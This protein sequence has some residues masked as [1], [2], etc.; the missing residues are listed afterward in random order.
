MDKEQDTEEAAALFIVG[1]R[2]VVTWPVSILIPADGGTFREH[3]V[4]MDLLY[5]QATALDEDMSVLGAGDMIGKIGTPDD[6]LWEK[7]LGWHGI[8]QGSEPMPFNEDN[9]ALVLGDSLIRKGIV[10]AL[11]EMAAG[12][13]AK[14]SETLPARG[15]APNRKGRRA[16]EK[17][18]K[19]KHRS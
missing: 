17:A 2:P 10:K 5:T 18:R 8:G 1:E 7:V 13:P 9:K 15:S 14:N 19:K 4:S 6:P 3:V 11:L 12:L 16:A